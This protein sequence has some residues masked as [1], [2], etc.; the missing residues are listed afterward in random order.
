MSRPTSQ[1]RKSTW[2]AELSPYRSALRHGVVARDKSAAMAPAMAEKDRCARGIGGARYVLSRRSFSRRPHNLQRARACGRTLSKF[3]WSV[4]GGRDRSARSM[5]CGE[6]VP[7]RVK[8]AVEGPYRQS[9]GPGSAEGPETKMKRYRGTQLGQRMAGCSE[10]GTSSGSRRHHLISRA[11]TRR[12]KGP[13][14]PTLPLP[15]FS[16]RGWGT[17]WPS[18]SL[19]GPRRLPR[20]RP[21]VG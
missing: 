10:S 9:Q 20:A 15:V 18:R 16:T 13:G 2:T 8:E 3:K 4:H 6:E 11:K 7:W 1:A 21:V 17:R 19:G 12:R 14:G 5:E